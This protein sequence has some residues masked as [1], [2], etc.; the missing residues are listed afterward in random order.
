VRPTTARR[1]LLESYRSIRRELGDAVSWW[2]FTSTRH[3]YDNKAPDYR[4]PRS[5]HEY[6]END[7]TRWGL[8][9]ERMENLSTNAAQLAAFCRAQAT[10]AIERNL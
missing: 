6:P 1:N 5:P 4:R 3:T 10:A 2:T 7:A 8:E 9:A